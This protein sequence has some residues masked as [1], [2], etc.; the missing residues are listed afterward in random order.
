MSG[1][2]ISLGRSVDVICLVGMVYCLLLWIAR[3]PPNLEMAV[4][5]AIA[6]DVLGG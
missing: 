1:L 4:Y 6:D 2:T 3:C 5:M